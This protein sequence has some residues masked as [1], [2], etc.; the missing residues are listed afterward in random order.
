MRKVIYGLSLTKTFRLR[1]DDGRHASDSSLCE[2]EKLEEFHI[3]NLVF[4]V[5][6]FLHT[7]K[8]LN[9]K[10]INSYEKILQSDSLP[11]VVSLL[12]LFY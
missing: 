10:F 3:S 9:S 11:I 1:Y 2:M 7:N 12:S 6:M 8:Q 4:I 5:S